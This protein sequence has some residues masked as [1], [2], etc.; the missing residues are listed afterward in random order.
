MALLFRYLNIGI[1]LSSRS[2]SF[3][4]IMASVS[5]ILS[6]VCFQSK[7][8]INIDLSYSVMLSLYNSF[9]SFFCWKPLIMLVRHFCGLYPFWTISLNSFIGFMSMSILS[10]LDISLLM[11]STTKA[12]LLFIVFITYSI[13]TFIWNALPINRVISSS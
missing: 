1:S 4:I 11:S 7:M 5:L 8:Q 12:F 6:I 2:W 3:R 13:S 10:C 9:L